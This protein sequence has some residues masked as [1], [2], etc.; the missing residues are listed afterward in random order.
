MSSTRGRARGPR[1]N[2]RKQRYHI[3]TISDWTAASYDRELPNI[4][5]LSELGQEVK[6]LHDDPLLN[7]VMHPFTTN[8]LPSSNGSTLTS[9]SSSLNP[10]SLSSSNR[11]NAGSSSATGDVIQSP[12][13]DVTQSQWVLV[14]SPNNEDNNTATTIAS[15]SSIAIELENS[16]G[17]AKPFI[18]DDIMDFREPE[19]RS[20]EDMMKNINEYY[21]PATS[22]HELMDR[23][24]DQKIEKFVDM[25]RYLRIDYIRLRMRPRCEDGCYLNVEK[26]KSFTKRVVTHY[27]RS[28]DHN[29][30]PE[31]IA[32]QCIDKALFNILLKRRLVIIHNNTEAQTGRAVQARESLDPSKIGPV[33]CFNPLYLI[34]N[35]H[36]DQ[37]IYVGK[38]CLNK[39]SNRKVSLL[40]KLASFW[41]S[42]NCF[43][44]K[45]MFDTIA[46]TLKFTTII[47]GLSVEDRAVSAQVLRK[48][49]G[50]DYVNDHLTFSVLLTN[51]RPKDY[52]LLMAPLPERPKKESRDR[53]ISSISAPTNRDNTPTVS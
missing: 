46:H 42:S 45:R 6:Q 41:K 29:L 35:L 38:A 12:P 9:S 49:K 4:P 48:T 44:R 33:M 8:A 1:K 18:E 20:Y 23:I 5:H 15:I 40:E 3:P 30:P 31:Q 27:A 26:A 10:N 39:M 37:L 17:T 36:I 22:V 14:D 47:S 7:D 24:T 11:F 2:T 28:Q 43:D 53:Y 32:L 50:C 25:L 16:L 52:Y 51:P 21:Y 34:L 19:N 13:C